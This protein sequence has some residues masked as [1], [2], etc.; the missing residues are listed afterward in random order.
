VFWTAKD[1]ISQAWMQPT[2]DERQKRLLVVA[3]LYMASSGT[4]GMD[5]FLEVLLHAIRKAQFLAYCRNPECPHRFFIARRVGQP[6][7][8][9]PCARPAQRETKRRWWWKVGKARREAA[10]EKKPREPKRP[11]WVRTP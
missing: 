7:C 10:R 2:E 4:T 3:G 1:E 11:E 9:R 6:Y 8:S 5:G